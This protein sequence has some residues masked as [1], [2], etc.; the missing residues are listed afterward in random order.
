ML[1]TPDK[2]SFENEKFII[3]GQPIYCDKENY[4]TCRFNHAELKELI[5]KC[6]GKYA[7]RKDEATCIV[8]GNLMD[9]TRKKYESYPRT[10][11]FNSFIEWL[12]EYNDIEITNDSI[13]LVDV[14][15]E[16]TTL[17]I[18]AKIVATI[19]TV[20]VMGFLLYFGIGLFLVLMIFLPGVAKAFLKGLIK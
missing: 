10:V 4:R 20:V 17:E 8:L 12:K 16:D 5:V 13:K 19:V 18:I 11:N 7:D 1:I 15:L 3:V 9:G 2:L 6:G 14:K